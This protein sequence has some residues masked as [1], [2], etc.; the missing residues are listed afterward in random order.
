MSSSARDASSRQKVEDY[1]R[2]GAEARHRAEAVSDSE[3]SRLLL[4]TADT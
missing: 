3:A 1:K 2:R 4:Q